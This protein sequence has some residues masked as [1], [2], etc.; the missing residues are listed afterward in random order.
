LNV[1]VTGPTGHIGSAL[2]AQL[3]DR[4]HRALA[5]ARARNGVS[6]LDRVRRVLRAQG[7]P[8]PDERLQVA[9]GGVASLREA[10]EEAGGI[11]AAIHAAAAVKFT[12]SDAKLFRENVAATEELLACLDAAAPRASFHFL[13]TAYVCGDRLDVCRESESD[14]GQGFRQPYERSKLLAEK[15]VAASS[16]RSGRPFAIYRPS[17]VMGSSVDGAAANFNG[18]AFFL[19]LLDGLA[20]SMRL[21]PASAGKLR[22]ECDGGATKNVVPVDWVAAAICRL[23][24]LRACG[25]V[26]HLTH[27][28]P[29]RHERILEV[30]RRCLGLDELELETE[31][32]AASRSP[33]HPAQAELDEGLRRFAPY[34]RGEPSFDRSNL[35]AALQG[36]AD[37]PPVDLEY[38]ARVI[39]F[40]RASGWR[41]RPF[42][43]PAEAR[44]LEAAEAGSQTAR[45]FQ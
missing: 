24:P 21:R 36:H 44:E 27:P 31:R 23:L 28:A 7:R 2:L 35:E 15:A 18:L 41:P 17:I 14:V 29:V 4:G 39:E 5:L 26:Y 37:P 42:E 12:S 34:L 40:G 19:K 11:D 6:A 8:S 22:I 16:R 13:S 33:P 32:G 45:L 38:F 10:I 3:L 9:S 20:R 25:R 1:L 30:A 43:E